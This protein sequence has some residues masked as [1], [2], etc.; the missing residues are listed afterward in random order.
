MNFFI[1]K[2]KAQINRNL[3]DLIKKTIQSSS[4]PVI[5]NYNNT[6]AECPEAVAARQRQQDLIDA[7]AQK[8]LQEQQQL[9]QQQQQQQQQTLSLKSNYSDVLLGGGGGSQNAVDQ[10]YSLDYSNRTTNPSYSSYGIEQQQ[11]SSQSNF[12]SYGEHVVTVID[13]PPVLITSSHHHHN[14]YPSE[15]ALLNSQ[16]EHEMNNKSATASYSSYKSLKSGGLVGQGD[17]RLSE[18]KPVWV[19]TKVTRYVTRTIRR[20]KLAL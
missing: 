1:K 11:Q 10:N 12:N 14:H 13:E 19:L 16:L 9:L 6:D 7:L 4:T 8:H 5:I 17:P 20:E 3:E 15:T 2:I 18:T